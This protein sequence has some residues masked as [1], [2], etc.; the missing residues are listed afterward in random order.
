MRGKKLAVG[1]GAAL[2]LCFVP[3]FLYA[4]ADSTGSPQAT[5]TEATTTDASVSESATVPVPVS[6][7]TNDGIEAKVREYFPGIDV[8]A[9]I[10]RCESRFRQYTDAGNPLHG[11]YGGAMIGVFQIH[12][13]VHAKYAQSLGMDI[14]TLEG[15]LAYAKRLYEKEGTNPW[16][17][18]FSCWGK[19]LPD[20]AP[21]DENSSLRSTLT[22]GV[23]SSEVLTLQKM[24]NAAGFAVATEGPGSPGQETTKFGALTR[25]AVR[26]FQ[27]AKNIACSGDEYTTGYGLVGG[28][29]RVALLAIADQPTVAATPT[30]APAQ[31]TNDAEIARLQALIAELTAQLAAIQ[32]KLAA[33]Q[34]GA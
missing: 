18:S 24:L 15:N 21:G 19:S 9:D 26:K 28:K 23:V 20:A 34:V 7:P 25:A 4:E 3:V 17:S 29:T 6:L 10:A 1:T 27:C 11:G 33:G 14:Y 12:E 22:M 32:K 30:P 2:L 8:M 31:T 5:S 13:T 16:I